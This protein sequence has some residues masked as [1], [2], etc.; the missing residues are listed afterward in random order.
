MSV[1][2]RMKQCRKALGLSAEYVAE[3]LH[4][5]AA[6]VYRYEKGDIDKMPGHILEPLASILN[7]TPAYLMGWE[8]EAPTPSPQ[9]QMVLETVQML[10]DLTPQE[11][12]Q[13]TAFVAGLK[14]ARAAA[15]SPQSSD[16]K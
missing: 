1:G 2:S 7:T 3:Q 6:T 8:E 14:A 11:V 12:V 13:V 5:S 10:M 16:P 9:Q 4:V 15:Q